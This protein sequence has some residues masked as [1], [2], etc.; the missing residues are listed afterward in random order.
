MMFTAVSS[1]ASGCT[2]KPAPKCC[3]TSGRRRARRCRSCAYA[4]EDR[5]HDMLERGESGGT[6]EAIDPTPI[7]ELRGVSK[8]RSVE[9]CVVQ[10]ACPMAAR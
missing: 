10:V 2:G 5:F 7:G 4:V 1:S 9:P 3:L 8:C 6:V